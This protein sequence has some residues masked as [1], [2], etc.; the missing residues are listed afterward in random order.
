MIGGEPEVVRHLDPVFRALAPGVATAPRTPGATGKPSQAECGYLHCGPNGGGHFVKMVHNGIEYGIMAAYSEGLNVIKNANAGLE[1]RENSTATNS[2][3]R[4]LPKSGGAAASSA[5]GYWTS[6]GGET[7][8]TGQD[9][10]GREI[11]FNDR[12]SIIYC[13][14]KNISST[15]SKLVLADTLGVPNEIEL[16]IPKK[17]CSYHARLVRSDSQGIGVDARSPGYFL[18]IISEPETNWTGTL[19][20][21]MCCGENHQSS[22]LSTVWFLPAS[23][24]LH[25]ALLRRP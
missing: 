11:I 7:G 2:T 24:G 19:F 6:L 25:L 16:Y 9:S 22:S 8:R 20:R 21:L 13:V 3:L 17:D 15:G 5:H 12:T 23:I 14:I 18:E 1:D 10:F 4:R